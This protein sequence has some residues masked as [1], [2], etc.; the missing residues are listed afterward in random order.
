MVTNL[1]NIK[2]NYTQ[3]LIPIIGILIITSWMFLIVPDL[4]NDF[5]A[6]E[7]NEE[8]RG[9][10]AS[11]KNIDDPLSIPIPDK[12]TLSYQVTG[13][14][15]NI[16]EITSV[17]R[18]VDILTDEI[19]WESIDVYYVDKTTRK[20]VE[21]KEGYFLFPY[22]LQKQNYILNHPLIGAPT[23]MFYEGT[24]FVDDLEVYIF[25]CSSLNEDRTS[26]YPEFAPET[27]HSDHTC[28][29]KIEPV[30]GGSVYVLTTWDN[31][32]I[33]NGLRISIDVGYTG[34]TEYAQD[35]LVKKVR[36][37]KQLFQFYD[38]VIPTFMLLTLGAIFSASVYN[39]KS[40]EKEKIIEKQF[41]E[42]KQVDKTKTLFLNNLN[43]ELRTP[44]V[45]IHGNAKLLKMPEMGELN[46]DQKESVDEIYEHSTYLFCVENLFI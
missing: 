28:R 18:A 19:T 41:E 6:F 31:Y 25:S 7:I 13:A 35:I 23:T 44:L 5:S 39:K 38:S 9:E 45:P 36:G 27:I 32:V 42:L 8:R 3:I 16:L 46:E 15:G 37:D 34:T 21:D 24:E 43:H 10:N 11:T 12:E 1:Q 17:Y 26:T 33:K 30:T 2:S 4:K 14:N 29:I 20:H 22:N 40:K